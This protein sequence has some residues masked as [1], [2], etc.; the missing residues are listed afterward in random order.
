[1]RPGFFNDNLNRS[2][3]FIYTPQSDLPDYAIVDF[4]CV[5]NSGTGFVDATHSVYLYAMRLSGSLIEFE[6]RSNAA[7][8]LGTCLLFQRDIND[9][10]YI[11]SY[12]NSSVSEEAAS[13]YS[14]VVQ[15][16]D[17]PFV[18]LAELWPPFSP[19]DDTYTMPLWY[20]FMVSGDLSRL[21]EFLATGDW[22][23]TATVEPS[24]VTNASNAFV[25]S[26][27]LANA[28]RTRATTKEDCRDLCWSF[29]AYEH[30]VADGYVVGDVKFEEGYNISIRQETDG[31][32]IVIEANV[33]A[34]KGEPCED[35][36]LFPAEAAPNG[37]TA[38]DGALRCGEVVRSLNGIGSRFFNITGGNGVVITPVP[39]EHKVIINADLQNMAICPQ[40]RDVGAPAPMPAESEDPCD[41]GTSP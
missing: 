3:P 39:D 41:C 23:N 2:Y 19:L 32:R 25:N 38:L 18:S 9:G 31:N 27:S 14:V 33:G 20:G 5:V 13:S 26:L 6:F 1:M 24:R 15:L 11:S 36:L 16:W 28:E 12:S 8:T 37:R 4:G 22:V 17:N 21:A 40:F 10:N 29:P 34:G 35:V 7:G 30:Y